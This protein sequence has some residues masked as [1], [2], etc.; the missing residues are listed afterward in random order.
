LFV[1]FPHFEAGAGVPEKVPE[2]AGCPTGFFQYIEVWYI[3]KLR[4][5][6]LGYLS[7]EE[8]EKK[9]EA[10]IGWTR[11]RQIFLSK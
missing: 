3:R 4:H 8:F 10:L 5:A 1:G 7:P 11:K 6:S 9:L 2:P